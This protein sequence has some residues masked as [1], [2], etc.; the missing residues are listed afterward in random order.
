MP[1][2]VQIEFLKDN[3]EV[4]L[5]QGSF[6]SKVLLTTRTIQSLALI[7]QNLIQEACVR[8]QKAIRK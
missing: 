8:A 6:M 5:N 4:T 2:V 1:E 7:V 3:K